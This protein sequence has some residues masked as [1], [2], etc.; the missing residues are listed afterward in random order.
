M[1]CSSDL[2]DIA[3]NTKKLTNMR[4]SGTDEA[5]VLEDGVRVTGTS[6]AN[7]SITVDGDEVLELDYLANIFRVGG[8]DMLADYRSNIG[9]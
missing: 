2:G 5:I 9:G 1:Q 6:A 8:E 4:A 3:G 7:R